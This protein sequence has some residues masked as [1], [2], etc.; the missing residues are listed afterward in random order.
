MSEERPRA[1]QESLLIAH[2]SPLQKM[3]PAWDRGLNTVLLCRFFVWGTRL[4]MA[5]VVLVAIN[6]SRLTVLLAV[7]LRPFLRG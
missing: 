5:S 1:A 6:L 7:H 2:S 4:L 3:P